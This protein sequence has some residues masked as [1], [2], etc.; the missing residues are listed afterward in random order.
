[1]AD[2]TAL[3]VPGGSTPGDTYRSL[4][5]GSSIKYA[6]GIAGFPTTVGTP[7]V[8]TIPT[9]V[10]LGNNLANPTTLLY[11][12]CLLLYDG[13]TWDAA[14][15]TSAD[16]LLVNVGG[17]ALTALQLI[18]NLPLADDADFTAG[19]TPGVGIQGVY[20][21][22][23]TNVT[24]GDIGF[25]GITQQ[26]AMKVTLF[27]STGVEINLASQYAEDTPS[28]A[29]ELVM[30]AG[31]VRKDTAATLASLD[32]D[33]TELIV[34]AN[35]RLHVIS[36]AA[37]VGNGVAATAQRVTIANDSTGIL[38]GVTTVTTVTTVAT[39]TTLIGGGVAHDSP[40]SGN[41]IK[42][43]AK[44]T[45]SL[46]GHTPVAAADRTD[47]FAA[48]DGSLLVQEGSYEDCISE[49]VT[50]TDGVSTAMTGAFAATASQ[51]IYLTDITISN[52]SATFCTVDIRDG[53]AGA[54]LWTFPVPATGGVTHVF[55]RPIR[56]TANTALAYDASAAIST[57][58]ISVSG[59]KSKA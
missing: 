23:P 55:K 48:T 59:F 33:R 54:V 42:V 43:G 46:L 56:F 1:M 14:P 35:G 51:R 36:T 29:A 34:D 47:L 28:V 37:V 44:A 4:E 38:A 3:A 19:T 32:G 2:N 20:E 17:A 31:V 26:R 10:A 7:D 11:G 21:T 27:D 52:S 9:A 41:P 16:G 5:D 13:A 18:D 50:N 39:V 6:V 8:V 40:D 30:M 15:G 45:A 22:S 12:S 25:V 49:R 24:A 53:A 58:S 57:L